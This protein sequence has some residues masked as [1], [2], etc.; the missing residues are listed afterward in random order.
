SGGLRPSFSSLIAKLGL[1]QAKAIYLEAKTAREDLTDFLQREGLQCDYQVTGRF[2]GASFQED[3]D[4][5]RIDAELHRTHFDIEAKLIAPGNVSEEVATARYFGGVVR[6]DIAAIHPAKLHAGMLALARQAGATVHGETG[7]SRIQRDGDR[8]DLWTLRGPIKARNI[9]VATNGYTDRFDRW[10]RRRL[11][12][13]PTRIIATEQLPEPLMDELMPQRRVVDETRRLYHYYR[14]SPDGTRILFGGPCPEPGR[15]PLAGTNVLQRNLTEI[16]PQLADVQ[17]S[18]SWYGYVAYNRDYLPR[19]FLRNGVHYAT[20]FCG[21]GVVW[22]RW[23]GLKAAL[24]VLGDA[25]AES[26][27]HT[28]RPPKAVPFYRGRPWFLPMV[29]SWMRFKD[30][31]AER[32]SKR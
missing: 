1:E 31:L 30:E 6:P 23:L 18:H 32:R 28:D 8:F 20:G 29:T 24:H 21:S 9:I 14:P 13:V 19:M 12:P 26:T 5:L 17:V 27:L 11:V 10:L 4:A 2:T 25:S 22:A 3:F 7:V 16:F 15:N